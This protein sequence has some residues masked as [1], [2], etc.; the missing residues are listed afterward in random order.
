MINVVYLVLVIT[1]G[2]TGVTSEKIPQANMKQ[3]EI[4]RDSFNGKKDSG[5]FSANT[6]SYKAHCIVGVQ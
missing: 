2:S 6:A 5:G 4:N 3:C 1:A